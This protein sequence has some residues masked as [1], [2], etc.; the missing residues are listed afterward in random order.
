MDFPE[1]TV[2]MRDLTVLWNFCSQADLIS[3]V[4]SPGKSAIFAPCKTKKE[5]LRWWEAC[6][7]FTFWTTEIPSNF[8]LSILIQISEIILEF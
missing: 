3:L 4:W 7:D 5:D 6:F 1:L 2:T 8:L